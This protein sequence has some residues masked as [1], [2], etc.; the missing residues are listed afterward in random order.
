MMKN[1]TKE[2]VERTLA[3]LEPHILRVK[4]LKEGQAEPIRCEKMRLL[5]KY[6]RNYR[7]DLLDGFIGE[8]SPL[9]W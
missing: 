4:E 2:F 8:K 5:Q 6:E 7:A 1:S 3:E 9:R